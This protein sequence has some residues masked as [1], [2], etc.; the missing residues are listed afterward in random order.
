MQCQLCWNEGQSSHLSAAPDGIITTF[1]IVH[2]YVC[3]VGSK[4]NVLSALHLHHK[5]LTTPPPIEINRTVINDF[6]ELFQHYDNQLSSTLKKADNVIE[7]IEETTESSYVAYMPLL[8]LHYQWSISS[9]FVLFVAVSSGVLAVTL[10][11]SFPHCCQLLP[12]QSVT[13]KSADV[14]PNQLGKIA[15]KR[16]PEGTL[17]SCSRLDQKSIEKA[18]SKELS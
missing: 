15:V 2:S 17:K 4:S 7:Q 8:H 16:Q 12:L 10:S 1:L 9:C 5:S 13:T 18:L 6:D 14:A 3:S 11:K